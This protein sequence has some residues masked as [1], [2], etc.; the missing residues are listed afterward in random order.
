M[1]FEPSSLAV[2]CSHGSRTS[3]KTGASLASRRALSSAGLISLM[4]PDSNLDLVVRYD[5][6]GR[7]RVQ[8]LDHGQV[9]RVAH[10]LLEPRGVLEAGE[11]PVRVLPRPSAE[12][13][14]HRQVHGGGHVVFERP[15]RRQEVLDLLGRSILFHREEDQMIYHSYSFPS[16]STPTRNPGTQK[17]LRSDSSIL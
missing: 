15:H 17:I 5:A 7:G 8:L 14:P 9:G 12:V 4:S 1:S 13:L 10:V 16:I 11:E 6:P 2:S 3:S